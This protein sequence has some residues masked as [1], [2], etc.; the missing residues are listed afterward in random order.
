[1]SFDYALLYQAIR[2]NISESD[3]SRYMCSI[4]RIC[5]ETMPN[6]Q[7]EKYLNLDYSVEVNNLS[8][9]VI[10]VLDREPAS[11]DENGVWFGINNPVQTNG[12]T[13]SGMYFSVSSEFSV[14]EESD[15]ASNAEHYPEARDFNSEILRNIYSIAYEETD[16]GNKAEYVF[17]LAYGV[18]LA[19]ASMKKYK[20]KKAKCKLGYAVGFDSGDLINFGRV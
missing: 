16:L 3:P 14:D 1:V 10:N 12:K 18:Q 19:R 7:W 5:I 2:D 15:W 11:F 13:S 9:H 20:E 8:S 17:C 4:V 6:Q